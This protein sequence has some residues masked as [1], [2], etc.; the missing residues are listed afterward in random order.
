M[1]D[2]LIELLTIFGYPIR[3]QGSI[4]EHE[5][6]PEHFFTY[7]ENPSH[8]G[9]HYDN[10]N[11]SCVYDF[12]VNFYSTDPIKTYSKLREAKQLLKSENFIISGDGYDVASDEETHTGRGMNVL[13]LQF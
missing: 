4:G 3:R 13:Y 10:K 7:W 6:Y 12:D 2:K 8:D 1:E 9:S 11:A 5:D